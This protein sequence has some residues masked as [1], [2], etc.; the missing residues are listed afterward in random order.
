MHLHFI[1][2]EY[3]KE[4]PWNEGLATAVASIKGKK[5]GNIY[6]IEFITN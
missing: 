3:V 1:K 4:C 2:A 6:L 5:L